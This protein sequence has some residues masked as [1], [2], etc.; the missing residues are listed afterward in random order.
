MQATYKSSPTQ[1]RSYLKLQK[2]LSISAFVAL[3]S[4]LVASLSAVLLMGILRLAAGIPTPVELFGDH[5]LKLLQAGPFVLFLIR[6]GSHAKTAPLGLAL[7]GMIGLGTLL[8]L[9]YAAIARVKLPAAGYRPARREWLTAGAIALVMTLAAVV[10]FWNEIRQNFFGLPFEWAMFT[11]ALAL[12]AD[13]GLY[14]L[15]L[16]LSYRAISPKQ[17]LEAGTQAGRNRRQLLARAGVAV[18]GLGAAGGT[19]GL[20]KSL[21]NN[22]SSYDGTET[23]PKNGFTAPI[24]PNS[25]HYVVTQNLVDP[26]PNLAVWRLEV[27]GMVSNPGEYTYEQ[28]QNLP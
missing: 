23:F 28:L 15:I 25:E 4:G 13:F 18:L 22:T 20:I 5:V 21:L 19:V 10:L 2:Q 7:L 1:E 24:T 17:H 9:L 8:G 26:A 12:F 16:C 3:C 14:A 11:T 27:A 6:F